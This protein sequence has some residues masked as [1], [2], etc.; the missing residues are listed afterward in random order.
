M[1]YNAGS[2]VHHKNEF[3]SLLAKFGHKNQLTRACLNYL[4]CDFI[5]DSFSALS[6]TVENVSLPFLEMVQ[7]SDYSK[8]I[9]AIPN[10]YTELKRN[11]STTLSEFFVSFNLN[12]GPAN[13]CQ[14]MLMKLFYDAMAVGLKQQRGR[15]F[16]IKETGD[17]QL[18]SRGATILTDQSTKSL[19]GLLTHNLDAE[20]DLAIFDHMA[21]KSVSSFNES[22]TASGTSYILFYDFN[23]FQKKNVILTE[24]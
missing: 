2:V 8:L 6:K 4:Q 20:R 17:K 18:T 9:H 14:R 3:R 10:V 1:G 7:K 12:L 11:Q 16:G 19:E 23:A 13:Q 21:K 22:C 5:L 24:Q 15:E